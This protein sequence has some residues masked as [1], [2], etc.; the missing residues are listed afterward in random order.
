MTAVT[1]SPASPGAVL[2]TARLRLRPFRREDAPAL[3]A[4]RSDP[5]VMR[6]MPGGEAGAEPER[7]AVA[8][9]RLCSAWAEAWTTPGGYAPWAVEWRGAAE[10]LLGHIGLRV[11][12]EMGGETEVLWLLRR[13]HW[14]GGLATEG[15]RAAV[16]FGLGALGLARIVAYAVPENTASLAVMRRLGMR[17]DGEVEAFGLRAARYALG[18]PPAAAPAGP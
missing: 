8:A 11:L 9:E 15:A 16:A 2:D 18:A 5:L 12:P 1:A 10:G 17:A 4:I 3:A 6:F 7:A 13:D 14:G